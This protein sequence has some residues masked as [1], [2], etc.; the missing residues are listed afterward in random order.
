MLENC[1]YLVPAEPIYHSHCLE[2]LKLNKTMAGRKAGRSEKKENDEKF[3]KAVR[4]LR[5]L[6]GLLP[7][8]LKRVS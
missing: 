1:K 6:W 4:V 2:K 7:I 5:K 8:Y 3:W